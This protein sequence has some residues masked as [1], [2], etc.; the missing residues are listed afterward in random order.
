MLH[1]EW[2]AERKAQMTAGAGE[3]EPRET[4]MCAWS[5]VGGKAPSISLMVPFVDRVIDD[6]LASYAEDTGI[7]FA[8][9]ALLPTPSIISF[10][11]SS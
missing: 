1:R 6:C 11:L 5:G 3:A 9:N 7:V 8:E 4:V 10:I 2:G